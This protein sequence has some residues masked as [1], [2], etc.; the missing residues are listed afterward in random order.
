VRL[1]CPLASP[2]CKSQPPLPPGDG[3]EQ[4]DWW[5]NPGARKEREEEQGRYHTKVVRPLRMPERCNELLE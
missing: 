2:D 3:C 4:I 1:A 5:F